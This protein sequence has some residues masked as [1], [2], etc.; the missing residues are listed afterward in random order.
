MQKTHVSDVITVAG[1]IPELCRNSTIN[2][3][4]MNINSSILGLTC[5]LNSNVYSKYWSTESRALMLDCLIVSFILFSYFTHAYRE[6]PFLVKGRPKININYL[7]LADSGSSGWQFSMLPSRT[8]N[9]YIIY[10]ST[11]V[12][13]IPYTYQP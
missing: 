13:Y 8:V 9:I 6:S 10:Q 1:G 7:A 5:K 11:M 3:L 2:C 12:P 4:Y